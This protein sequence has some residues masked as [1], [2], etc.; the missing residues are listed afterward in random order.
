VD[1]QRK[2]K[3]L[4]VR[5]ENG[6]FTKVVHLNTLTGLLQSYGTLFVTSGCS[7]SSIGF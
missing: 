1:L 2:F 3:D 5:R 4:Q 7:S 6:Q